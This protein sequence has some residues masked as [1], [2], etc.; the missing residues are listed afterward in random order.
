MSN[1]VLNRN[2][3]FATGKNHSLILIHVS[4]DAGYLYA[5]SHDQY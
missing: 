2:S 1:F 4:E 3:V 5:K